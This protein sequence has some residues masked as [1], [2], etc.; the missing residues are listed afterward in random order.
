MRSGSFSSGSAFFS[1]RQKKVAGRSSYSKAQR[2]THLWPNSQVIA[3][4]V[5]ATRR[6][7]QLQ[8]RHLAGKP[9]STLKHSMSKSQ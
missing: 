5:H 9:I 4:R 1:S 2:S 6:H 3:A 8:R 7:V